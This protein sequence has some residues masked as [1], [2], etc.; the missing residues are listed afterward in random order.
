MPCRR[1]FNIEDFIGTAA[2]AS[3]RIAVTLSFLALKGKA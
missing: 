1:S 2:A 3:S